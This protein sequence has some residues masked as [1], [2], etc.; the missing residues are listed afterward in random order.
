MSDH[1][2]GPRRRDPVTVERLRMLA[3][4]ARTGTIAGAARTLGITA[5]AVSQQLSALERE[6]EVALLDRQARQVTLTAAGHALVDHAGRVTGALEAASADLARLRGAVGGP[7][8][9]ASVTSAAAT[10]VSQAVVALAGSHPELRVTVID[11]EPA[12]SLDR[13]ARGEV[14]LAVV[15]EYDHAPHALVEGLSTTELL[16]EPLLVVVPPG[17]VPRQERAEG[18]VV[19]ADPASQTLVD[20]AATGPA[21]YRRLALAD[22]AEEAWVLAPASAACGAAVR[23]ACRSLG[24]RPDVRWETDDLLAHLHH[25]AAGHGVAVLPELAVHPEVAHVEVHLLADPP[26]TRRLLAV[27]RTAT[28]PRPAVAAVVAAL[29]A[30]VEAPVPA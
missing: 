30:A 13:L 9:I 18:E 15:D 21:T 1:G 8:R 25:V 29:T 23:A 5:S 16:H 24:F 11:E 4:V 10:L 7:F 17:W 14:D 6:T 12:R 20:P 19:V 28:V 3:E 26:L 27:T 22:L 2:S